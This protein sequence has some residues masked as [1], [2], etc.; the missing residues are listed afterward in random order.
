AFVDNTF[1]IKIYNI[2]AIVCLVALILRGRQENYNIKNLIL[3]LSIF[4]IGLLDLIWY[5]AFKIDNSPFR[6]TYHSY[7]N[8]AKIFIFGSFIVFLTLTSQ[9]KSK[10]ESVLYTLYSLSFLI[11]GYAMYINSIHENDR[12]SFGVG[13]ATGAAYST[14]LIGIVSGV[15][16]LYTKKNHP[17]LFLLN[18]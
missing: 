15:A 14:M 13:T 2:T 3:P 12:I 1:S 16:I 11:A 7:L 9:L 10:K 4:L 8:T 5:S 17:F 18:S 6:A